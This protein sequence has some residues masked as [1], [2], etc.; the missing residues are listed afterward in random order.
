VPVWFHWADP[1]ITVFS[2][3]GTAKVHRLR[4]N[5]AVSVCL[6]TAANGTDVVTGE[7]EATLVARSSVSAVL[8]AFEHKYRPMLGDRPLSAWLEEFSQPMVITLSKIIA[9][10]RSADGLD[11]RSIRAPRAGD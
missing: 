4:S 3:A 8:P 10:S 9:W 7:G 1:V 6:D 5:P 2:Q 11:Y